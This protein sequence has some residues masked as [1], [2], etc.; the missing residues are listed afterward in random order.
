[1][2]MALS[3]PSLP[4][5][6]PAGTYP[7]MF[8]MMSGTSPSSNVTGASPSGRSSI[9]IAVAARTRTSTGTVSAIR[10]TEGWLVE[11]MAREDAAR[12]VS[13]SRP[14]ESERAL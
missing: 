1:M 8:S 13:G 11:D 3:S 9:G 6:M 4:S 5:T 7:T 14:P 2:R 10:T 12:H